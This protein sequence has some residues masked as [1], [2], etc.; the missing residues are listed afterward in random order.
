MYIK[1]ISVFVENTTGRLA[2]FTKVLKDN[3][4]DM[5]ALC[6][7]DTTDFGILR[8]LVEKPE[9]TAQ[10]LKENGFTASITEVLAVE[11]KD[12]PGGLNSILEV[13]SAKGIGV[14][15][16]YS[17][18]RSRENHAVIIIKVE[19]PGEAIDALTAAGIQLYC[20][21]DLI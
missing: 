5:K 8:C 18:I 4:I 6:I 16:V 20:Q 3:N 11:M 7:A 13:L 14:D 12:I 9:E 17:I 21:K 1:Q 2:E 15:Y 10:I 19:D